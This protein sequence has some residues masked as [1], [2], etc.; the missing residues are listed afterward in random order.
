MILISLSRWEIATAVI[1]AGAVLCP[2]TTLA[3]AHDIE[4]RAN[5]SGATVFIGDNVSIEKFNT[6]RNACPKIR[7]V[8]QATGA[9]LKDTLQYSSEL[10]K[11]PEGFLYT[12]TSRK[13]KSADPSM[14]YFTSGTTGMPKMVLHNQVSYP[15]GKY[16]KCPSLTYVHPEKLTPLL[17]QRTCVN[18]QIVVGS[19]TWETLLELIG[20]R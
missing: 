16:P 20:A 11:I 7:I 12:D 9:P 1:R 10:Q 8:L 18:R 3:V 2:C 19:V 14:I 15:L 4:Y 5:A 17:N 6:V 13:T